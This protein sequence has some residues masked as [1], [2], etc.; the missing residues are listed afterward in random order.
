[1]YI[2]QR[3]PGFD[4]EKRNPNW[5]DQFKKKE[6]NYFNG[7]SKYKTTDYDFS[8]IELIKKLPESRKDVCF[9]HLEKL[10][11]GH[12]MDALKYCVEN[13]IPFLWFNDTMFDWHQNVIDIDYYDLPI[14]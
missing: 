13:K 14:T 1:M 11:F 3:E 8:K 5:T 7:F 9:P 6:S 2:D 4:F 12:R 10:N